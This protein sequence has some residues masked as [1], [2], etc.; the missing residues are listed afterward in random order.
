M[1]CR[2]GKYREQQGRHGK[3]LASLASD[4]S[5]CYGVDAL[6]DRNFTP[7]EMIVRPQPGAFGL[8]AVDRQW[9][10]AMTVTQLT[11]HKPR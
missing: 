8:V 6:L 5:L 2:L 10:P 7:D 1:I 9:R 11:W 4:D 3:R